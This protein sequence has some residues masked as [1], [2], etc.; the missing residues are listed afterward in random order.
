MTTDRVWQ[1]KSD[2][3]HLASEARV[4]VMHLDRLHVPPRLM[5]GSGPRIW[6]HL[7]GHTTAQ[8]VQSVADMVGAPVDEIAA[9]VTAFVE[10]LA[11]DGLITSEDPP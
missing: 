4:V 11:E 10:Q 2:L 1:H 5:E 6:Q 7:P 8:V 3:A 9:E